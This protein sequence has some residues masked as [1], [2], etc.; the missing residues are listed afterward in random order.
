M[1]YHLRAKILTNEG[2]GLA[3]IEVPYVRGEGK[4]KEWWA[5]TLLPGGGTLELPLEKLEPRTALKAGG[6]EVRVLRAALPGVVPGAVIDYGFLMR[7]GPIP[8]QRVKLQKE[9]PVRKVRLRWRPAQGLNGAYRLYAAGLPITARTEDHAIHVLGDDLPA[10]VEEPWMPPPTYARGAVTLY[11]VLFGNPLT[12]WNDQGQ[13]Y[14]RV[15][16][17]FLG[18]DKILRDVVDAWK[19]QPGQPLEEKLAHAYR[20]VTE[21]V[22]DEDLLAFE[23]QPASKPER[24]ERSINDRLPNLLRRGQGSERDISML[25]VGLARRLGAEAHLVL[26]ADRRYAIW[27]RDLYSMIPF[28]HALVEVRP[29]GKG[30]D[31]IVLV[32]PGSGLDYGQVPWWLTGVSALLSTKDGGRPIFVPPAEAGKNLSETR[33]RLAIDEEGTLRATWTRASANARGFDERHYLR[34]LAPQPRDERLRELCAGEEDD[35]EVTGATA[36]GLMDTFGALRLECGVERELAGPLEDGPRFSFVVEGPWI[37]PL[38]DFEGRTTRVHPVIFDYA[39]TD[40]A[41]LEVE[42]PPGFQ[43]LATDPATQDFETAFGR[44]TRTVKTTASGYEIERNVAF[45]PMQVPASDYPLLLG[46]L[47]E[48]RTADRVPLVFERK[49]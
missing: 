22:K 23:D 33:A 32:D 30:N 31:A 36:P 19:L 8:Y 15:L 14:E 46:F 2:R 18:P 45:T 38:P 24:E 29:P 10:V 17:E 1:R 11:Y 26:A 49:P 39:R 20:W 28:N 40:K 37:D 25:F 16:K 12:Y 21:H 34:Q 44:Y 48:I 3:D 43:P 4:I 35:F 47:E 7:T 6:F 27:D 42:A 41:T 9:F 13:A 5:R